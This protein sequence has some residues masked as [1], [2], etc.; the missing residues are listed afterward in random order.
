MP[1]PLRRRAGRA[2]RAAPGRD[3]PS[4]SRILQQPVVGDFAARLRT[5]VAAHLEGRDVPPDPVD[6]SPRP[7]RI[8]P[9][10]RATDAAASSRLYQAAAQFAEKLKAAAGDPDRLAVRKSLIAELEQANLRGMGGAG[11]PAAQK[12]R[13]VLEARGDEKY[14]VC[15]AD[16]SEPATFKDRELLLR[17][18]DLVIEGMVHGG[19]TRCGRSTAISTFATNITTRST[20]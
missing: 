13:D 6:R 17:T 11:T 15:N 8:D 4:R 7:W 2:R 10:G 5:I 3:S 9:Y 20:R 14:I 16:E 12:W 18:P 1:G 19:P